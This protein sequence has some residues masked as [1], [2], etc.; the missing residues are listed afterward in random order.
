M[1]YAA[2]AIAPDGAHLA[3]VVD[4]AGASSSHLEV[5]DTV[6]DT[7]VADVAGGLQPSW[8]PDGTHLAFSTASDVE[9]FD[10][11]AHTVSVVAAAT[12]ILA[13][14]LWSSNTT[15]V[16]STA[17][18]P[19]RP[20]P[21]ALVDRALDARYDLPGSPAAAIAV[22]VSPAGTRIALATSD[23]GVLVVPAAGAAGGAQRL[24]GRLDAIGFTEEGVLLAISSS[25]DTA[26]LLRISVGGGDSS[27][28]SLG[29]PAPDLGTVRIAP[30][31]RRL[32]C[33]AVDGTGVVQ[34]YVA[35]A[36]GSG[37]LAMT[38]FLPGGMQAQA[39]DFSD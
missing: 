8:S 7:L 37:E 14:P 19:G 39:V 13:A 30:D 22:A 17:A 6:T 20:G 16:I 9:V 34:A 28:V 15:L 12:S 38:R 25:G 33:L 2:A 11:H 32:A 23:G 4:S 1:T 18:S 36:D 29:G 24:N 27:G 26:Q 10:V 21:V 31:G 5:I 3:V 35:G